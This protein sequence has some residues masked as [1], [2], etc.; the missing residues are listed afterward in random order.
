M[1]D[2]R[3][4]TEQNIFSLGWIGAVANKHPGEVDLASVASPGHGG[5]HM[6]QSTREL[7]PTQAL[8]NL[9]VA[10][11]SGPFQWGETHPRDPA[12]PNAA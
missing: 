3:S 5:T 9:K 12:P 8:C 2:G 1:L 11:P 6:N 10:F 4:R 7:V